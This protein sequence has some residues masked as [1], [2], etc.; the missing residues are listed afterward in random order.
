MTN[1]LA[2]YLGDLPPAR[3]DEALLIAAMMLGG[4]K[5]GVGD[6][7]DALDIAGLAIVRKNPDGA[8]TPRDL[9]SEAT[10]TRPCACGTYWARLLYSPSRA[11]GDPGMGWWHRDEFP[12]IGVVRKCPAG[13]RPPKDEVAASVAARCSTPAS[14]LVTRSPRVVGRRPDKGDKL[15]QLRDTCFRGKHLDSEAR[16]PYVTP[17]G[18]GSPAPGRE[19][20]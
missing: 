11:P 15:S 16:R 6:L 5:A 8:K 10:E 17:K 14:R 2:D 18:A 13:N 9:F 20:T 3:Q 4:A 7:L 19:P 1:Q 12:G